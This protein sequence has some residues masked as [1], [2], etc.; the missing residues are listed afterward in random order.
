MRVCITLLIK[1]EH[2]WKFLFISLRFYILYNKNNIHIIKAAST[3]VHEGSYLHAWVW[4][5]TQD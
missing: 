1:W 4:A 2:V 5:Q 3:Q